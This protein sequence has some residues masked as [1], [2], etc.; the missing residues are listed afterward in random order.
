MII[1]TNKNDVS[2][3][4]WR[5]ITKKGKQEESGEEFK[6]GLIQMMNVGLNER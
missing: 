4:R 1:K 6:S 5:A 2:R 3:D